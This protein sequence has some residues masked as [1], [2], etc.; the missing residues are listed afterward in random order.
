MGIQDRE[1]WRQGQRDRQLQQQQPRDG[2]EQA[3]HDAIAK[4]SGVP[5][6]PIP[7]SPPSAPGLGGGHIRVP[8]PRDHQ[9]GGAGLFLALLAAGV[10][11]LGIAYFLSV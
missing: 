4:S 5:P 2:F 10:I 6:S 8:T 3:A 1:Y 7:P 11:A 9:G